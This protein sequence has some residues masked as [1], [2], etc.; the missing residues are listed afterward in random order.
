MH[1]W[2]RA[3][4]IVMQWFAMG[5]EILMHSVCYKLGCSSHTKKCSK[6]SFN[7]APLIWRS[8][9]KLKIDG[10]S[11]KRCTPHFMACKSK[12]LAFL[13]SLHCIHV[14]K[15]WFLLINWTDP[16]QFCKS[17]KN[18]HNLI[19]GFSTQAGSEARPTWVTLQWPVPGAQK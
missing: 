16:T 5:G 9:V 17:M 19:S 1:W 10:P 7:E 12:N 6:F 3:E 15:I 13:L 14:G 2:G 11:G 18:Q 8:V 4:R